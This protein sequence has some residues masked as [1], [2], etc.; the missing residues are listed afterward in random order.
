MYCSDFAWK[1]RGEPQSPSY[2]FSLLVCCITF[3]YVTHHKCSYQFLSFSN[4]YFYFRLLLMLYQ[5]ITNALRYTE[6]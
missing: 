3:R 5:S 4:Q 6:L 1:D 2:C